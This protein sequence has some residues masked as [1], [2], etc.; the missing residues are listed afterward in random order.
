M[1]G[2]LN[3]LLKYALKGRLGELLD[4]LWGDPFQIIQP[5]NAPT[6][7]STPLNI[8]QK[9]FSAFRAEFSSLRIAFRLHGVLEMKIASILIHSGS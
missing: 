2:R 6:C 3:I 5:S 4:R 1:S 7:S 8:I 9:I